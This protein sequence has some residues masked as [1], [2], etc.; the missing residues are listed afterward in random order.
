MIADVVALDETDEVRVLRRL[1]REQ[2]VV[3]L[4]RVLPTRPWHA[5]SRSIARDASDLE[6]ARQQTRGSKHR[7]SIR[8]PLHDQHIC[9]MNPRLL[10]SCNLRF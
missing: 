4:P 5:L 3:R 8:T 9:Q 2:P 1:R 10:W 6:L 7:G